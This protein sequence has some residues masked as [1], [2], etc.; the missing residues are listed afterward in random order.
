MWSSFNLCRTMISMLFVATLL[1]CSLWAQPL[2]ARKPLSTRSVCSILAAS[3]STSNDHFS[4]SLTRDGQW[5]FTIEKSGDMVRYRVS[6]LSRELIITPAHPCLCWVDSQTDAVFVFAASDPKSK[7]NPDLYYF[8]TAEQVM[9]WQPTWSRRNVSIA[10]GGIHW[11]PRRKLFALFRYPKDEKESVDIAWLNQ[12]GSEVGSTKVPGALIGIDTTAENGIEAYFF[13]RDGKVKVASFSTISEQGNVGKIT[14]LFYAPNFYSNDP[15]FP[16]SFLHHPGRWA[17]GT[18]MF[19]LD[20]LHPGDVRKLVVDWMSHPQFFAYRDLAFHINDPLYL[21]CLGLR[22]GRLQNLGI[23]SA[24]EDETNF[25]IIAPQIGC[26]ANPTYYPACIVN[27][28]TTLLQ[29][30]HGHR[31]L[32]ATKHRDFWTFITYSQAHNKTMLHVSTLPVD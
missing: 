27:R 28:A 6:D 8:D 29:L 4:G 22:Y 1:N 20:A 32:D 12:T 10:R 16:I 5:F 18:R 9:R 19:R 23:L 15:R 14:D 21:R 13:S 25:E 11:V 31:I 30:P 24:A 3:T 2:P 17:V 7:S 26:V